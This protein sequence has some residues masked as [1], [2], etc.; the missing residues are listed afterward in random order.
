L[1]LWIVKNYSESRTFSDDK[2]QSCLWMSMKFLQLIADV[3]LY[4]FAFG[5]MSIG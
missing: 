3:M 5:S 4:D 1:S 2:S